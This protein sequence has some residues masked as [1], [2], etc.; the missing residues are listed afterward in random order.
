MNLTASTLRKIGRILIKY[1]YKDPKNNIP[2]LLKVAKRAVGSQFP[3][4]WEALEDVVHN[5][6]NIWHD[7]LFN[8]LE[9]IDR[10]LATKMILTFA[11]DVGLYGTKTIRANRDKLKCNCL[12]YTSPSP[13]S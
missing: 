7:Y 6:N 5:E 9:N 4:D 1:V 12:L 10:E 3:T 8:A 13:R 11:I 2:K